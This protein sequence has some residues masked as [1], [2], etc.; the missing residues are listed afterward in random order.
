MYAVRQRS[1]K[2]SWLPAACHNSTSVALS[3]LCLANRERGRE[4]ES[5]RERERLLLLIEKKEIWLKYEQDTKFD[6]GVYIQKETTEL[7]SPSE[8]T[9]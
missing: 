9:G 7:T 5:E 6:T 1:S 4:R 2:P 3:L 8:S